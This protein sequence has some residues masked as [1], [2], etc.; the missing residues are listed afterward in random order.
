MAELAQGTEIFF[1]DPD[2]LSSELIVK[3]TCPKTIDPGTPSTDEHDT[4]NLC[5]EAKEKFLGLTDWASAT[6]N[7]DYDQKDESYQRLIELSEQQPRP[8]VKFVIG[9]PAL[10]N[11][12]PPPQVDSN[13]EWDLSLDRGWR[14]FDGQVK[15]V[16]T[17]AEAGNLLNADIEIGITKRYKTLFKGR[18]V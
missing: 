6:L 2:S 10:E 12:N 15:S 7:A 5:S 8:V 11:G 18:I 16:A 14:R 17:V 4:T 1:I 3:V 9:L 13:G